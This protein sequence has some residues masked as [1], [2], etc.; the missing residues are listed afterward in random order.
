MSLRSFVTKVFVRRS[1][2]A[3]TNASLNQGTKVAEVFGDQ[4]R[5][6]IHQLF[7]PEDAFFE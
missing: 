1:K 3:K 4:S 2:D 6:G 5:L 7:E